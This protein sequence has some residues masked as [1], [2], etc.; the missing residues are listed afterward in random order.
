VRFLD[1]RTPTAITQVGYYIPANGS[2]WAAYWAPTDRKGEIV[3][4]ADAYRGVD[5]L[6]I[7]G[8][9]LT[10]KKVKAPVRNEWFGSPTADSR[11][12]QT[13]PVYGFMCPLLKPD[14]NVPS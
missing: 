10:G 1:Y 12:F 11:S 14:V 13:H 9:G 3:Y 4:T 7:D 5:V 2:T 8:A 6:R